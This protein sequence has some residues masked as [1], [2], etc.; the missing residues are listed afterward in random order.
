MA[1]SLAIVS[2]WV[3]HC[4]QPYVALSG[5]K[6]STA[7]L[8][9]AHMVTDDVTP[10]YFD[11]EWEYPETT[12]YLSAIPGLLR[13][14]NTAYHAPEF[15]AWNY[16]T[17]PEHLTPG[18]IWTG[19]TPGPEWLRAQGFDGAVIGLRMDENTRRRVHILA[20]GDLFER[21][22]GVLQCYPVARWSTLDIW[23]FIAEHGIP[24]NAAYDIMDDGGVPLDHQRI[25]P[26]IT[27]RAHCGPELTYTF[28]PQLWKRFCERHP[29]ATV[30][31][32]R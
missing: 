32:W 25:G 9:L 29:A 4:K 17:P 5:G 19:K 31:G 11:D 27:E 10:V 20:G 16:P 15:T 26:I 12:A 8:G 3:K 23:T 24:Y 13:L 6:D 2:A 30:F 7:C 18:A 1:H 14:A 28:W 21:K 22:N